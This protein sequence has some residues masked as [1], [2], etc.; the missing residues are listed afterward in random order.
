MEL[1][2]NTQL[3]TLLLLLVLKECVFVSLLV[4]SILS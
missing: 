3:Q 2:L 4:S 1:K